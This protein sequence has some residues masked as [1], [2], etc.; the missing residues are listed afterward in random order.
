MTTKLNLGE[1]KYYYITLAIR[2]WGHSAKIEDIKAFAESLGLPIQMIKASRDLLPDESSLKSM[3]T[4]KNAAK[5]L[6]NKKAI[7]SDLHGWNL[8]R[9]ENIQSTVDEL[10]ILKK[11]YEEQVED[12][13]ET[14]YEKLKEIYRTEYPKAFSESAYPSKNELKA[15]FSFDWKLIEMNVGNIES[16]KDVDPA[17]YKV[18]LKKFKEELDEIRETAKN[19]M[20]SEILQRVQTLSE[21]CEKGKVNG[22]TLS[23]IFSFLDRFESVYSD[24]LSK[25]RVTKIIKEVKMILEDVDSQMFKVD[26]D[27]RGI[28]GEEMKK[29]VT[30]IKNIPG[31]K[32]SRSIDL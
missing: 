8:I 24:I 25:D 21:Q 7:N 10:K 17:L 9:Q 22:N 26:A 27:L 29:A 11:Q 13:L 19:A 12:F 31:V 16:L 23:G 14:R 32:L 28:I 1:S 2:K 3:V 15:K 18:E 30:E 5:N 4:I 20:A 6:L